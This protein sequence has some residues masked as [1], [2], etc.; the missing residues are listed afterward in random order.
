MADTVRYGL[1]LW[2]GGL[3]GVSEAVALGIAAEKA[4]WDG[5]FVPDELSAGYSDPWTV[6]SAI[7]QET[8]G[9][10]L[11]TWITP[12]PHQQPWRV[13]HS[14]AAVDRLSG[15]RLILGV[16]LGAPTE[17]STFGGS[18]EPRMLG[19]KYDEALEVMVGLWSGQPFSYSGE[20]FDLEE[21]A[22]AVTPVQ[23]PRIPI[24]MG[25]WWPNKKPF[26]RAAQWDGIMPFWPALVQDGHGPQ[27]EAASGDVEEE[28]RALMTYYDSLIDHPGEVVIPDRPEPRYRQLAIELGATWLLTIEATDLDDVERGPTRI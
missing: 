10:G 25:C 21:A 16:G 14:A 24:L 23:Q 28:L 8:T 20:F 7:A 5:V 27:G 6:L 15:G 4:G 12:L 19:R 22:L 17:H 11:G 13:A 18:Y 2:T 26:E 1:V 3:H 9:I